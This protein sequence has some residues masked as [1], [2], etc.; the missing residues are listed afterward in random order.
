[1]WYTMDINK[2]KRDLKTNIQ[3]GLT[4]KEAKKRL[5]ENGPNKL[6][7]KKNESL[8]MRFFK[9][10]NDFMII[11]LIIASI[12]SAL[13]S[14]IEGSNDYID[15]IIIIV[16]VVFN[17]ILGLIQENKAEKSLEALKNMS[18]PIAKVKRD[19]KIMNVKNEEV[20]IGDI[21]ILEAGAF[22]PADCRIIKSSNNN[23]EE[24]SNN[25]QEESNSNTNQNSN[26]KDE[27]YVDKLPYTGKENYLEYYIIGIISIT[28]LI[29]G[30]ILIKKYVL[31][32]N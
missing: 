20:V 8:I 13:V 24:N 1:M 10:F 31:N 30:S 17:A 22:V 19:G 12:I 16:I 11:I 14:K 18:S 25:T 27:Y 4:N 7:D 28:I 26:N 21:V 6:E 2:V 9:Q 32:K 15:S 23:Q 29:G 5:E 3:L